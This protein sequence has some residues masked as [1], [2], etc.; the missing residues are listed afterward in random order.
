MKLLVLSD[1]H[2]ESGP[3]P[4]VP[5]GLEYDTV[6]LA[7]DIDSPGTSAVRWAERESTFGGRPVIYVPGNHEFYGR[8]M[9]SELEE[10]R[11]AA[12][13]TSVHVLNRDFFT[14][15][16]VR[17]LGT[18]LWTDFALPIAINESEPH[19]DGEVVDVARALASA[20]HHVMDFRAI[21]LADPSIPRHRGEPVMRRQ[22]RAEDTLYMHYIDR[23]WLRRELMRPFEGLTVVVTH[24]AP[25]RG[26]VAPRCAG[27]SLTPAFVSALPDEFFDVPALWVHG[28]THAP[29]DYRRGNCRVLSNPRGY[30]THDGVWENIQFDAGFVV[31]V[32]AHTNTSGRRAMP[33]TAKE[34]EAS[35]AERSDMVGPAD[36]AR[37][38]CGTVLAAVAVERLRRWGEL[39]RPH[40]IAFHHP[41]LGLRYPRWQFERHIWPVVQELSSAL[42]ESSPVALLSWL[43]TPLG[44]L[45]GRTPRAALE[46]GELAERVLTLAAPEGL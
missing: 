10:M 32:S 9:G 13:S 38:I 6:V 34:H 7:G 43:E 45:S 22:L 19:R 1:L 3:A 17:F 4:T 41:R 14:I 31:D 25:A 37:L 21:Q 18:T 36:A 46:Q 11:E 39:R 33:K 8:E 2:L 42:D 27:D 30:R 5:S 12:D 16:R 44:A 20:N 15:N 24:H 23:D 35:L 29:A 40:A 26:S 28:H